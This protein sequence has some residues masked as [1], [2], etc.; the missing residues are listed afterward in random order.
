MTCVDCNENE[1]DEMAYK[2]R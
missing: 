2:S 1:S